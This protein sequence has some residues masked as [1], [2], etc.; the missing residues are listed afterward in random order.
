MK[1][2][3]QAR[4]TAVLFASGE[5]VETDRLAQGL[6]LGVEEVY[7]ALQAL[8]T[9]LDEEGSGLCLLELGGK[10][11]LATRKQY[12]PDIAAVLDLKKNQPLSQAAL[13]VLAVI[14]Y[15][16]PV[17]RGF[18]EQVRGVDCSG[19]IKTLC[20]RSLIEECGRLDIPSRP[21]VYRTTDVFLRCFS[22]TS[23]AELPD[24]REGRTEQLTE[25][26]AQADETANAPDEAPSGG[27]AAKETN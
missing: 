27:E 4:L 7:E 2:D 10:Y 13:E 18:V 20:S 1:S 3:T 15:N 26:P 9:R 25:A 22:M 6:D 11:Q 17:T 14:A 5:P 12:R 16:Q 19:V 24:F 8:G 21:I 23:L